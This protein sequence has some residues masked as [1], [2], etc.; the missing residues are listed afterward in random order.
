M[1]AQFGQSL[2]IPYGS[3]G[4]RADVLGSLVRGDTTD[5]ERPGAPVAVMRD[6]ANNRL[7]MSGVDHPFTRPPAA[8]DLAHAVT[9]LAFLV[10]HL[11]GL[12]GQFAK[13]GRAFIAG[14][15][16]AVRGVV[17]DNEKALMDKAGA[18]AGL[19]ELDH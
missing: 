11:A 19:V 2:V 3:A 5:L 17:H 4:I 14:Y 9:Q 8:Q 6:P 18:L 7:R 15:F 10:Q 12:C 16:A 13:P 1:V